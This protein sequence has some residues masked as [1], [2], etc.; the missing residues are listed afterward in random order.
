[1]VIVNCEHVVFRVPVFCLEYRY[2][3]GNASLQLG[4]VAILAL[5]TGTTT[6]KFIQVNSV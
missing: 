5:S 3:Y 1:M 4:Q 6:K 2:W